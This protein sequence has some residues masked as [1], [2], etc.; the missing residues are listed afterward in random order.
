MKKFVWALVAALALASCSSP[1]GSDIEPKVALENAEAR[2]LGTAKIKLSKVTSYVHTKYGMGQLQRNIEILVADLSFEKEVV[3]AHQGL[4]GTWT[5]YPAAYQSTLPDGTEVWTAYLQEMYPTLGTRFALRYTT[6]QGTWWDNNGGQDYNIE[7]NIG[8]W[9]AADTNVRLESGFAYSVLYGM[10]DVRNLAP[11][12]T[13]E[14]IW[15]ADNWNTI[16]VTPAVFVGPSYYYGYSTTLSPNAY[17]IEKW[18]FNVDLEGATNVEYAISY[19]VAG[20]NY[21]DNN[22]GRNYKI[23]R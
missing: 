2:A 10:I 6:P 11:T 20:K 23:V 13:V 15:T 21:W 4:D 9:L 5:D 3:V 19:N 8:T 12:K 7:K 1:L 22:F 17:G 14:I 16:K 18:S